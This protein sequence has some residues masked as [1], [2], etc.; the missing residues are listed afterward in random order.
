M[1][2]TPELIARINELS[3][4]KRAEGLNQQELEEQAELRRIY[5]DSIKAQVRDMLDTIEFVDPASPSQP[6]FH[7][8]QIDLVERP[9][10]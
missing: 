5:L 6:A 2:I 10:H 1:M 3:R 4:K 9:L 7:Q 8:T